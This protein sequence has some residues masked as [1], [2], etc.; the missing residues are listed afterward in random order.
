MKPRT[1]LT[2]LLCLS[3]ALA[4]CVPWTVR[5]IQP[6][7]AT[8]SALSPAAFVDSIWEAKLLP[9]LTG[10]AVDA[11]L[12]LDAI[13]ASPSGAVKRYGHRGA[14]GPAYF[15]VAGKG[16]VKAL[17]LRSRVGLALVDIEPLDGLPDL[18]IQLGPVL[19][20]TSLR[21]AT[22]VIRFSDFVN[23]LQYADAASAINAR[24]LE[25]ILAP[26]DRSRL[27]GRAISFLGA[28]PAL[29]QTNPPLAELAPVQL[30][31]VETP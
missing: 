16:T 22:G 9:S 10:A 4:S 23:Q 6:P 29:E 3:G 1:S 21:D 2:P 12:L 19:R 17:D 27:N 26:I 7:E 15:V 30:A 14:G 31:F 5:P 24:V 28:L 11:R 13:A 20:G 18:S 8:P 25:T